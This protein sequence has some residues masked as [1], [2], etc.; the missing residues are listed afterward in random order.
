MKAWLP[1][2]ITMVAPI[3]TR[4][5]IAQQALYAE[6]KGEYRIV[7]R[8]VNS[9]AYVDDGTGKLVEAST[10]KLGLADVPQFAPVYIAVRH[11]KVETHALELINSG[12]EINREFRFRGEFEAPYP[13]KNVFVVLAL[14]TDGMGKALFIREVGDLQ[15]RESKPIDITLRL[16]G[17]LGEGRYK[18]HVFTDGLE[19][20]QS[21]M[22]PMYIE[23]KLD[24]IVR[25]Q[26]KGLTNAAPK[27]FIGPVPEYPE[28]LRRAKVTGTAMIRF[29]ISRTGRV[30]NPE[31]KSA[32]DPGFGD[33]A[34]A[35]ARQWRF[36]PKVQ[37]GIPVQTVAQ[38]PFTFGDHD[39]APNGKP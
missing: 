9:D 29:T 5:V 1:L 22:P 34:L 19:A 6:H 8:V 18:L 11:L 4:T 16:N 30:L 36:L 33:A 26:I 21:E 10:N 23:R 12:A 31:I 24:D 2:C 3:L 28:K 20:F 17:R 39:Q 32:S 27:P 15:P 37:D 25:R 14:D 7:R 38:M 35:A 13:L